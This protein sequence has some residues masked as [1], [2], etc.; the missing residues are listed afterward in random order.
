MYNTFLHLECEQTRAP[1][2]ESETPART[3]LYATIKPYKK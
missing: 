1:A 2:S 3:G